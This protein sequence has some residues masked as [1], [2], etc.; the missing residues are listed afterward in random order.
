MANDTDDLASHDRSLKDATPALE[1]RAAIEAQMRTLHEAR[2]HTLTLLQV[3]RADLARLDSSIGRRAADQVEYHVISKRSAAHN[4]V[5][6]LEADLARIDDEVVKLLADGKEVDK[7][8]ELHESVL[9]VDRNIVASSAIAAIEREL[10]G[11]VER[12]ELILAAAQRVEIGLQR[13]FLSLDQAAIPRLL[14]R[15]M[16]MDGKALRRDGKRLTALAD[17]VREKLPDIASAAAALERSCGPIRT[18][19]AHKKRIAAERMALEQ[20]QERQRFERRP[21]EVYH[22]LPHQPSPT[23][24]GS[25]PSHEAAA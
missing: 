5:V 13:P 19:G 11:L 23:E 6:R 10:E 17:T 7:D 3:A 12:Y 21:A 9:G 24:V 2:G 1:R 25:A 16:I 18:L 20:D 4:D 15:D 22:H 8:L 14:G